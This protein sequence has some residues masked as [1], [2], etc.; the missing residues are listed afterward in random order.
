MSDVTEHL[1]GEAKALFDTLLPLYESMIRYTYEL[2]VLEPGT[3]DYERVLGNKQATEAVIK[4]TW[5]VKLGD[6]ASDLACKTISFFAS[7]L[8]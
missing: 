1:A 7:R 3:L 2:T 4:A 5:Q 6:M 8:V